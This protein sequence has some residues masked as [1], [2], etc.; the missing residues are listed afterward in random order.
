MLDL[1]I[2]SS[3]IIS[4]KLLKISYNSFNDLFS[5][6]FNTYIKNFVISV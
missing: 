3:L 5:Y 1:I 4:E 2:L 6:A